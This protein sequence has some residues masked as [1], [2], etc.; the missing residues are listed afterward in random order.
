MSKMINPL[1]QL[2]HDDDDEPGQVQGAG[3]C[4]QGYEAPKD[5]TYPVPAPGL[6]G[7]DSQETEV[8][9]K[10]SHFH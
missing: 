4:Y 2:E 1:G 7:M 8:S 6:S 9:V 5:I 3:S 10:M